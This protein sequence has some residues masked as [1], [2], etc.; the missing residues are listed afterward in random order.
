[1]E[2]LASMLG[3]RTFAAKALVDPTRT[4]QLAGGR[5]QEEVQVVPGHVIPDSTAF[6]RKVDGNSELQKNKL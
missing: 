4:S 2:A 6:L 3:A 1:M 5:A